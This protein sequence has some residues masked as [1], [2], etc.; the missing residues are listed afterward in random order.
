MKF[1][2]IMILFLLQFFLLTGFWAIDIGAS[3]M[4]WE[5]VYGP[6]QAA[7][8]AFARSAVTQYHI[9]LMLVY[10]V[11]IIQTAWMLWMI[12]NYSQKSHIAKHLYT[13]ITNN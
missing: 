3:G 12:L 2:K 7:G 1:N 9:G 11:F 5:A 4:V 6:S 8:L 13:L 10:L